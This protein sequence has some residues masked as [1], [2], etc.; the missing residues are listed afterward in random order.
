MR[1]DTRYLRPLVISILGLPS[2]TVLGANYGDII[3]DTPEY[4]EITTP[5]SKD[6]DDDRDRHHYH[7][8]RYEN[9]IH[10][11]D[12]PSSSNYFRSS[13]GG[14]FSRSGSVYVGVTIGESEFDYNDI[15]DG[16]A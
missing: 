3:T 14:I 11:P 15:D 2:F 1:L 12:Y 13:G 9:R 5:S 6:K 7:H 16:D 8:H 4:E 10:S